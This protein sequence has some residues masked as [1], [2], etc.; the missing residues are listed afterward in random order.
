[1]DNRVGIIEMRGYKLN[2]V[3]KCAA[4]LPYG[5]S[6]VGEKSVLSV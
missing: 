1:M 2:I 6:T 4:S 5:T 3:F